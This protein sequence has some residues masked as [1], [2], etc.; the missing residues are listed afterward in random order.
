MPGVEDHI[1]GRGY[2]PLILDVNG[3]LAINYSEIAVT[4]ELPVVVPKIVP[5]VA[6]E[7]NQADQVRIWFGYTASFFP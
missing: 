5:L 4:I 6:E 3:E 2:E 1:V 7:L